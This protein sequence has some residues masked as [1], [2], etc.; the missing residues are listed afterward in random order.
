MAR[1]P[2]W[3]STVLAMRMDATPFTDMKGNVVTNTSGVA[4]GT[5]SSSVY[6]N[7]AAYFPPGGGRHLSVPSS[8]A[9]DMGSEDFT[10]EC[11]VR[12]D[13][14]LGGTIV[15]KTG[16]YWSSNHSFVF[17][18]STTGALI[19]HVSTTGTSNAV[20]LT[21]NAGVVPEQTW[22][23]V[24]MVRSGNTLM[25]CANGVVVASAAF[26]QPVFKSSTP[27]TIGALGDETPSSFL[28][29]YIDEL[30]IT[31]GIARYPGAIPVESLPNTPPGISGTVMDTGGNLAERL[32]RSHRRSDGMVGGHSVST[33]GSFII[34]AYDASP[35]Y[36]VCFDDDL[37]E[38]ALIMDN[39]TP[40]I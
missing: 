15:A 33:G 23:H 40:V 20:S 18:I 12:R 35:H 27:L 11:F 28:T 10:I 31:K 32:V 8:D 25:V 7:G 29:G 4:L 24:A 22:T 16:V 39:I 14:A 5:G 26:S 38:N 30:R 6:G 17:V 36:V 19:A 34:N 9:F 21:S 3:N 1:D 13:V 37:D 2:Y